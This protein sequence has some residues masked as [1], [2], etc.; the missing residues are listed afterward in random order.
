MTVILKLAAIGCHL[1]FS[2][3]KDFYAQQKKPNEMI[4]MLYING[5]AF[6]DGICNV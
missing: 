3:R 4:F 2:N 5:L 1:E 6:L